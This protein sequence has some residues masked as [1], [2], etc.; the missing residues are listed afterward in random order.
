M[1]RERWQHRHCLQIRLLGLAILVTH[2]QFAFEEPEQ[3]TWTTVI[4][5]EDAKVVFVVGNDIE[6]PSN[7]RQAAGRAQV[8]NRVLTG[9]CRHVERAKDSSVDHTGSN[10]D[11][12]PS[13][14]DPLWIAPR[15]KR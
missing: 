5:V 8:L 10:C 9:R 1:A 3:T 7:Q 2:W 4:E 11:L 15:L 13:I 6:T 12:G 14:V